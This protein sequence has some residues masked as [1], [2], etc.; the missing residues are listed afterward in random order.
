[1]AILID[2][3]QTAIA[4]FYAMSKGTVE[5]DEDLMRHIILNMI[6]QYRNQFSKKYGE[7][8]I[9]CDHYKNWR[10]EIFPQYK[11]N[12]KKGREESSIDW[13][14]LFEALN[15]VREELK[16]FMPYRVIQIEG[17]EADDII[18][19]LCTKSNPTVIVSSDKDFIQLQKYEG[20]S[21]WSPVQKKFIKGNPEESLYE[22][23]IKGD[24]GDGVPNILSADETLINEDMRQR[25]ISKKKLDLWRGQSPEE[26]CD[27]HE[28][29]RNYY[30]NK[31][32]VDLSEIP[33]SIRINIVTDYESQSEQSRK[34]LMNYFISKRLKNLM[35]H[36]EEF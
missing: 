31:Q 19:T 27:T 36:I 16:Q 5:V 11:A 6:R 7:L 12:R 28:M 13:E 24:T 29:L 3:S 21:Q 22:K 34:N 23:I 30:R 18:A 2:Y 32:M 17:A 35:E 4:S 20:V 10:K 1:M 8:I 26:F 14:K 33:E 15:M 25:P 9:C